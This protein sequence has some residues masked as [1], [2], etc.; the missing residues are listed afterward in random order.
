MP[1]FRQRIAYLRKINAFVFEEM[2]M[3][4]IERAGHKVY[5]NKRY[6]GDGGIDGK[7]LINGHYYLIQAKRYTGHVTTDHVSSFKA[8]SLRETSAGNFCHTGKNQTCN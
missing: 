5:R 6:T 3:E 2:L 8:S 7:A 1:E 4:A